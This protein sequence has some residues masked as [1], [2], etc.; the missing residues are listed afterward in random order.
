MD[1]R[2]LQDRGK[3]AL[4]KCIEELSKFSEWLDD[5]V[6]NSSP[7]SMGSNMDLEDK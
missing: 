3:K 4:K 2:K 5:M 6:V 1:R 7:V